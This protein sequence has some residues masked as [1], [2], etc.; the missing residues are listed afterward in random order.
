MEAFFVIGKISNEDFK[1]YL[2]HMLSLFIRLVVFTMLKFITKTWKCVFFH[3]K[4]TTSL[5]SQKVLETV[6][7]PIFRLLPLR[8]LQ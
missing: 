5:I 3:V 7:I 1:R 4:T 6:D 8:K 2:T